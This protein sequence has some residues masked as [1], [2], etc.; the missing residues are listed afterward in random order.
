[1]NDMCKR[2]HESAALRAVE[3]KR[4]VSRSESYDVRT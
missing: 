4:S 2:N 3:K 1:M